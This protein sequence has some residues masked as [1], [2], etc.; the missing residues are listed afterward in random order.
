MPKPDFRGLTLTRGRKYDVDMAGRLNDS[1][2]YLPMKQRAI[3]LADMMEESSL[4][5]LS[6]S[7]GGKYQGLLQWGEDRY[8]IASDDKEKELTRQL[9]QL[10][11]TI[12]N[13]TDSQSSDAVQ[14]D[15]RQRLCL[16]VRLYADPAQV[17]YRHGDYR[18]ELQGISIQSFSQ[19]FFSSC[20]MIHGLK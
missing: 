18:D 7:K 13:T 17:V 12:N 10:K 5:P 11:N 14:Q 8:R 20:F 16:L 3:V 6:R 9:Q 19:H 15:L 4:Y 1:L 2:A